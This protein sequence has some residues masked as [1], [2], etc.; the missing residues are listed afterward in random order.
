MLLTP[1]TSKLNA[2]SPVINSFNPFKFSLIFTRIS[3]QILAKAIELN[4]LQYQP[5]IHQFGGLREYIAR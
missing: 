1:P 4:H 5:V 2:L 3:I